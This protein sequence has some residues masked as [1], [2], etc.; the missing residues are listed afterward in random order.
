MNSFCQAI[1]DS[2]FLDRIFFRKRLLRRKSIQIL[3]KAF[4]RL[5]A[6]RPNRKDIPEN[7]RAVPYTNCSR[8]SKQS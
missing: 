7:S 5:K 4:D 3:S 6:F 2:V 1:T 8:R